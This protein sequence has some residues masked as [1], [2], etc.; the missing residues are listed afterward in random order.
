LRTAAKAKAK[1]SECYIFR[2]FIVN[3]L[4]QKP[5]KEKGINQGNVFDLN[6]HSFSFL[7]KISAALKTFIFIYFSQSENI[8]TCF[9]KL[10]F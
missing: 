7:E 5:K 2:Y 6:G 4:K 3:D 1:S 10:N 8:I 9:L